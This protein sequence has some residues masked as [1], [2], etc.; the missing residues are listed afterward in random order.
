MS[1]L[2]ITNEQDVYSAQIE[3]L[4]VSNKWVTLIIE[5]IFKEYVDGL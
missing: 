1:R 5:V 3:S 4:T 2:F